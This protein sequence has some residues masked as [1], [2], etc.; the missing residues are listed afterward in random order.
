MIKVLIY[1][2]GNWSLGRVNKDIEKYISDKYEFTFCDWVI[3]DPGVVINIID[4]FDIIFTN[5]YV[6][7]IFKKFNICLKKFIFVCHGYPEFVGKENFEF[8]TDTIYTITSE[9]IRE[10]FPEN[11]QKKLYLTQT[12]VDLSNFNFM[13]RDGRIKKIGWCGGVNVKSKRAFWTKEIAELTG[14]DYEI[15][16]NLSFDEIVKWYNTIDIYLVNSGP[17]PWNETGPLP[18]FEAIASGVLAIGTT[19]GNFIQIPGPKYSTIEEAVIIINDLKNN[20]DKVKSLMEEQYN[21]IINNFSY[22][23][24]IGNWENV[25]AESLKLSSKIQNVCY[26]NYMDFIEIGTSDFDTEIQK[27]GYETKGMSIEPLKYYLDKLPEKL[28]VK[29]IN[30]AISDENGICDIYYVSEKNILRYNLPNWVKGCNS[31][32]TYHTTVVKLLNDM[33][34]NILEIIEKYSIHKKTLFEVLNEYDVDCVFYLKIDTEGHDCKILKKFVSDINTNEKL[35]QVILFEGNILTHSN[36][37]LEVINLYENIGYELI[38]N[39][40]DVLLK[41][42][43]NKLKNKTTFSKGIKKYF[44]CEYPS[45]YDPLNLPHDNSLESAQ[46]YCVEN[47]YSGVTF[48]YGRYEVRS[49]KYIDYYDDSNLISW[50][51][52]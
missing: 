12:G 2:N 39:N 24:I 14:L 42:N 37:I 3:Y 20:P 5:M 47:S 49:G 27:A 8:P 45:N 19:V 26:K 32:N 33:N 9:T 29:K 15:H 43:F 4:N 51:Y 52:L 46:K 17:E 28:Q 38:Y 48:Q 18:P 21:Y 50:I 23:K 7:D 36:D 16:S 13:K 40:Y 11:L 10:L 44:I 22:S 6:V 31:I 34:L 1:F 25:L 30:V 35:P 41:L